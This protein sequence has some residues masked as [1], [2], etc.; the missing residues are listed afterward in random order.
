MQKSR[1]IKEQHHVLEAIYERAVEGE[2]AYIT[3]F[4]FSRKF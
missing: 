1:F 3:A 2:P 4:C